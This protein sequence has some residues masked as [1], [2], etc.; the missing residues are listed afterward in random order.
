MAACTNLALS[1]SNLGT[2]YLNK[3]FTIP[4]GQYEELGS[5]MMMVTT[6]GLVLP[7]ITVLIFNNPFRRQISPAE[8][9]P[10][11]EAQDPHNRKESA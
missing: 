7:I 2:S 6:M 9:V 1:A 5:L 4:R 10:E 8:A 11:I 3:I